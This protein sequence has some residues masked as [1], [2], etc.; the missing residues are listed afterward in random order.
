M[1][2]SGFAELAD[3]LYV[4]AN[5]ALIAEDYNDAIVKYK[6]ILEDGYESVELYYNLGNAYYR[7]EQLGKSIWAYSNALDM[8]PRNRDVAHNLA[9]ANAQIVDRIEM[10][11]SFIFITFYRLLKSIMTTHE[12]IL[13]G[14]FLIFIKSIH[15]SV[16]K[17]GLFRV[18][19]Y[20]ITSTV[21]ISLIILAHIFAMD[22]YIYKQRKNS[23]VVISNNVNA[24]SG[25]FYGSSSILFQ[26]N[27]GIKVDISNQQQDW[28]EIILIDGKKGWIPSESIWFMI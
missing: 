27:E 8:A 7:S 2:S 23:A 9:I 19:M 15:F 25:P 3:E 12:W 13:F 1:S 14:S 16:M 26:I 20:K 24:Y 6:S 21:L 4:E 17:F 28:V 5:K 11:K 10:P 22:S 18:R